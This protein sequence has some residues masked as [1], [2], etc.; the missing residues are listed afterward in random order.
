LIL[1]SP[2]A[3]SS[4]VAQVIDRA[5]VSVIP[6]QMHIEK[7]AKFSRHIQ[8]LNIVKLLECCAVDTLELGISLEIE[9]N[10]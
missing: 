10:A 9:L 3:R 7:L 6:K 5:G 4:F 1:C 2:Y 8:Y